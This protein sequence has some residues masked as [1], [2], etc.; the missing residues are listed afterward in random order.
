VTQPVKYYLSL[1]ITKYFPPSDLIMSDER[2]L[3]ILRNQAEKFCRD[4]RVVVHK[5]MDIA[6][7]IE[8]LVNDIPMIRISRKRKRVKSGGREY[9]YDYFEI[10]VDNK[11]IY[12][13]SSEVKT[14]EI[15]EKAARLRN[16]LTKIINII[17]KL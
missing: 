14:I 9:Y 15:I 3:E 16:N 2:G 5:L 4:A 6:E 13:S 8:K 12:I 7:E 17:H 11:T 10:I 1:F